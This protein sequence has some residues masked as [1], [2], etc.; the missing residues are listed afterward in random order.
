VSRALVAGFALVAAVLAAAWA[1]PSGDARARHP[2]A[3]RQRLAP[4]CDVVRRAA[5]VRCRGA[6][7]GAGAL[8]LTRPAPAA[9]T[10][11][12]A[13]AAPLTRAPLPAVTPAPAADPPP[14]PPPVVPDDPRSLGVGARDDD[15]DHPRLVLSRTTVT[16]GPVRV[17]YSLRSAQ[18]PHNLVLEP[19]GAGDPVVFPT[20]Q[21]GT[22]STRTP[23]LAPGRWVLYCALA[24][25]RARGMQATLT[26]VAR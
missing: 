22:A 5:A 6:R 26:V 18:D 3:E 1:A 11:P 20:G 17:E 16:S 10:A 12:G 13:S 24:D 9:A 21:P 4:V 25:H 15:L 19:D 8:R 23:T 14:P 7:L 2:R